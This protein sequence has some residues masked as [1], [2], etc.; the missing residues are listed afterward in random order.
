MCVCVCVLACFYFKSVSQCRLP[1]ICGN[2]S[3][4]TLLAQSCNFCRY[5]FWRVLKYCP[6][7]LK[8]MEDRSSASEIVVVTFSMAIFLFMILFLQKSGKFLD[9]SITLM[10]IYVAKSRTCG[11]AKIKASM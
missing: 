6:H 1:S 8:E 5:A 10:R 4:I 11:L 2:R 9:L 3:H 7:S